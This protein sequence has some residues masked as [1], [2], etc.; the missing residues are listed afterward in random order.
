MYASL[1]ELTFLT[2]C[3]NL[4]AW[5]WGLGIRASGCL[6]DWTVFRILSSCK[7]HVN[8]IAQITTIQSLHTSMLLHESME[9]SIGRERHLPKNFRASLCK[10]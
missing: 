6:Y 5:M 8:S 7:Q 2:A 4:P 9:A 3:Y 1:N 10:S